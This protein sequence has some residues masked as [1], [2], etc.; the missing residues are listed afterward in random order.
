MNKQLTAKEAVAHIKDGMHVMIGG[1]MTCGTPYSLI[2]ALVDKGVKDLTIIA[3]DTGFPNKGIGLLVANRQVKK[4]ITSHIGTNKA[5]IEQLNNK[6]LQVEFVPQGTLAEQIRAAGAGLG[7]VLTPTGIGTIVEEGKQ[8]IEL[9]GIKYILEKALSA[10]VALVGASIADESGNLH[11]KGTTQNFNPL[12]ATAA[13]L[14]IAEA[15]EIVPIGNIP[16]ESVHTQALF[17]DY[18]VKSEYP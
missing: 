13:K 10:D 17:V 16:Q 5:T 18:L 15:Q 7:G 2:Q 1:F 11:Y 8:I 3:N 4:I 12:M 14:V 9:D 6:E